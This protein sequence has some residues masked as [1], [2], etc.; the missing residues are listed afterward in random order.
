MAT[1]TEEAVLKFTGDATSALSALDQIGK[2]L[3]ELGR[4]FEQAQRATGGGQILNAF[5]QIGSIGGSAVSAFGNI[6]K[7]ILGLLNPLNVIS[8]G[9]SGL[10]GVIQTALGVAAGNAI[11]ALVGKLKELAT[12]PVLLAARVETLEGVF[13]FLGQKAGYAREQLGGFLEGLKE[14][15]ITT[16]EAATNLTRMIQAQMDL[17]KATDL[18]RVAQDAAVISGENSSD[19]FAAIMHGIVSLSPIVLRYHGIFVNLQEAYE[20]FAKAAG[21]TAA[22]LSIQQKQQIALDAVLQA[23]ANITGAY[24]TAMDYAGKK[25]TSLKRY[26]EEAAVAL[27]RSF[28]PILG[29]GI[30]IVGEA[31]K[32]AEALFTSLQPTLTA[33]SEGIAGGMQRAW[34]GLMTGISAA[35][36]YLQ[37]LGQILGHYLPQVAARLKLLWIELKGAFSD[38]ASTIST[39]LPNM[40][41]LWTLFTDTVKASFDIVLS[42]LDGFRLAL[43]G[44]GAQA[45][46]NFS[47]A[48]VTTKNPD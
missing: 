36:P 3:Q 9:F 2:A 29:Q 47:D 27:G 23:G 35:M 39:Y 17:S 31:F 43:K 40:A 14:A 48:S 37:E 46:A 32:K 33:F 30:D 12:Q 21:T 34:T 42:L 44:Q 8:A 7:S 45:A 25:L 18:A 22:A 28:L 38:L 6:G 4:S 13:F 16:R 24:T 19:A 20:R 5:K 1:R 15:G 10:G 26:I 11:S 41:S